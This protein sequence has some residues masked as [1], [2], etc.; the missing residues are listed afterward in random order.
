MSGICLQW[1]QWGLYVILF[2]VSLQIGLAMAAKTNRARRRCW[3][4]GER[5]GFRGGFAQAKMND[6]RGR[7]HEA[8]WHPEHFTEAE[9]LRFREHVDKEGEK[10][11][12]WV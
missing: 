8:V 2:D 7:W 11:P 9:G 5:L 12:Y 10:V 3:Q 1:W 4:C 6:K